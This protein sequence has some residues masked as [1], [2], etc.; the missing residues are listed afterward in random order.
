M[1]AEIQRKESF[2]K[3]HVVDKEEEPWNLGKDIGSTY[4]EVRVSP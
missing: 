1:W 2:G 3:N 4:K